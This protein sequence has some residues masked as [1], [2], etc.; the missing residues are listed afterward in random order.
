MPEVARDAA[1]A[2][3][4]AGFT[5]PDIFTVRPSAGARRDF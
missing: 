2:F 3:A 4:D 5:E 1:A